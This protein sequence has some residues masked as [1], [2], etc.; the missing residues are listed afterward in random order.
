MA[1][2]FKPCE[3]GWYFAHPTDAGIEAAKDHAASQTEFVYEQGADDIYLGRLSEVAFSHFLAER[4]L[5]FTMNGGFNKLPDFVIGGDHTG[6]ALKCRSIKTG[7]MRPSYVVNVPADDIDREDIDQF[8]FCCY[9]Y[10][11]N[12]ML[13]LGGLSI[14]EFK[15]FARHVGAGDTLNPVTRAGEANYS[16]DARYLHPP[17]EW[18]WMLYGSKV[19]TA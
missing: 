15:A 11:I 1:A 4:F 7:R 6:V 13:L 9:E 18:L 17:M 19:R 12:R 10:P 16:A 3:H 8:F 14:A 2:R 5:P